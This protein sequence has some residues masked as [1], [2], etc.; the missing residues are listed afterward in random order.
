[1]G[2][3]VERGDRNVAGHSARAALARPRAQLRLAPRGDAGDAALAAGSLPSGGAAAVA[4]RAP[5]AARSRMMTSTSISTST[6]S[7]SAS[8]STSSVA[9]KLFNLPVPLKHTHGARATGTGLP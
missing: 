4:P 3:P 8:T 1:M 2:S 7:T 9:R 6:S 5:Q